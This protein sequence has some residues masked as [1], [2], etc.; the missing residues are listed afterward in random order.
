MFGNFRMEFDETPL[1]TEKMHKES[2]FNR[3]MQVMMHYSK[4]GIS[5]DKLEEYVIGE[6]DI[7]VPHT[8]LRGI[9]Y[10]AKQ[11]LEQFGLPGKDWIYLE[12]G[13]YYWTKEIEVIEDAQLLE[14][15]YKEAKTLGNANYEVEIEKKLQLYLDACY[16]YAGEFLSAYI[17]EP[18]VAQEA[19]RYRQMFCNCVIS[20][21]ELLRKK[22]SWNELEK[23]GRFATHVEPLREWEILVMEALMEQK[24]FDEASD[25]YDEV[26]DYYLKECGTYP[27]S[28]LLEMLDKYTRQMNHAVEVLDDIQKKIKENEETMT[29]GYECSFPIFK[30]I[31]QQEVRMTDRTEKPVYLM[32]CTLVDEKGKQIKNEE[33]LDELSEKLKNSISKSIRKSDVYTQ[34]GKAQYLVLLASYDGDSCEL[35]QNRINYHFTSDCRNGK[36]KCHVNSVKCEI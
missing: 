31:Y 23:L 34:Y 10:K 27:S 29:R 12:K 14:K 13:M 30:G 32:L 5:K 2:Q 17:A 11:K 4:T 15:Y 25:F 22:K 26:V 3:L 24:R 18:W 33:I 28:N 20:A 6:R 9:V 21:T 8:A 7:G 36:V 16:T 35:V 1:I 19:K